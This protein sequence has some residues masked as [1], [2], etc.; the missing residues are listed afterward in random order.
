MD[1]TGAYAVRAM[2]V[3]G[4]MRGP[5]L[6]EAMATVDW[7]TL[8]SDEGWTRLLAMVEHHL[9][10]YHDDDP[11]ATSFAVEG[12]ILD[13][14]QARLIRKFLDREAQVSQ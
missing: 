1:A 13:S 6:R 7:S 2:M 3:G 5:L 10:A 14:T 11:S 12:G 4:G 8:S 9:E